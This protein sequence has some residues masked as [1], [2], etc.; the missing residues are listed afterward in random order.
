MFDTIKRVT[1]SAV[2]SVKKAALSAKNYAVGLAATGFAAGTMALSAPAHATP[3]GGLAAEALAKITSLE[4]DVQSILL[5]L[6]G[7][8]FLFVLFAYIKR[9]K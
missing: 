8:V 1:R 5:I 4:S 6:V 9:A 2:T 7:V 3:S